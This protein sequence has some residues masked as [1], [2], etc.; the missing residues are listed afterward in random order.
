MGT[1]GFQRFWAQNFVK[2]ID[3]VNPDMGDIS[4][5]PYRTET[6]NFI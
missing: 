6:I 4:I 5:M 1:G 3:L 2:V